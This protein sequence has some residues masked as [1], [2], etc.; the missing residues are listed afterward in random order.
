MA[1]DCLRE[2]GGRRGEMGLRFVFPGT[3]VLEL[4]G[5]PRRVA[6]FEFFEPSNRLVITDSETEVVGSTVVDRPI[7]KPLAL[8]INMPAALPMLEELLLCPF[9]DADCC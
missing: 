8:L 6:T 9:L 2:T 7:D 3:L 1:F 5:T 4:K